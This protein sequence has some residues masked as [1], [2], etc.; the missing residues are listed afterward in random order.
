[1][2]NVRPSFI[3]PQDLSPDPNVIEKLQ[4]FLKIFKTSEEKMD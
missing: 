3:V 2:K 4:E 1:V